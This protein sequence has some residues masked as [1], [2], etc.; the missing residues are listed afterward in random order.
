MLQ[1]PDGVVGNIEPKP[2]HVYTEKR[3]DG[4]LIKATRDGKLM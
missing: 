1:V 3:I 2:E 4:Q